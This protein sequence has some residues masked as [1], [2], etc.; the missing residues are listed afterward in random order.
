MYRCSRAMVVTNS[1]YTSRAKT[2]GKSNGCVLVDR[3]ELARLI[4]SVA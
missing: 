2:L 4:E 3:V 1:T